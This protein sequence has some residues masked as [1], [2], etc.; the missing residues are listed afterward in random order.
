MPQCSWRGCPDSSYL[1]RS[2]ARPRSARRNLNPCRR[3]AFTAVRPSPGHPGPASGLSQPRRTPAGQCA[4]AAAGGGSAEASAA[5]SPLPAPAGRCLRARRARGGGWGAPGEP[6][7]GRGAASWEEQER[8]APRGLQT[9]VKYPGEAP[10]LHPRSASGTR[11]PGLAEPG[12]VVRVGEAEPL[13]LEVA[14]FG[15]FLNEKAPLPKLEKKRFRVGM[16][17]LPGF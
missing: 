8:P 6:G 7:G 12:E 4:A 1:R 3:L 10:L 11:S 5:R 17:G 14:K 15:E 2:Q 13:P 16:L 9:G